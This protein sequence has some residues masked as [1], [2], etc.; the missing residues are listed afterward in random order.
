MTTFYLAV[1]E[2]CGADLPVPFYDEDERDR[3]AEAHE[4]ATDH[5]VAV[6][7]EERA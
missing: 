7:A 2:Q 1:C 3:W 6:R 5:E 4:N